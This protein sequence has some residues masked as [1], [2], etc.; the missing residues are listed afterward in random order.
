MHLSPQA[1]RAALYVVSRLLLVFARTN[2]S[3]GR[4][5]CRDSGGVTQWALECLFNCP[6]N[7]STI[8]PPSIVAAP[9]ETIASTTMATNTIDTPLPTP[10]MIAT[11]TTTTTTMVVETA[12]ATTIMI[13]SPVVVQSD[14]A[15]D[16]AATATPDR[17]HF[18]SFEDWRDAVLKHNLQLPLAK[19][20]PLPPKEQKDTTNDRHNRLANEDYDGYGEDSAYLL[21]ADERLDHMAAS[22]RNAGSRQAHP[23]VTSVS[24]QIHNGNNENNEQSTSLNT[25]SID[26]AS[27]TTPLQE[28]DATGELVIATSTN[29]G[30]P[31][32]TPPID[33]KDMRDQS[34]YASFDCGATVLASNSEAKGSTAILFDTKEQYMLNRC[35]ASK[36]VVIELCDEILVD[37][38]MLANHEFFS[39]MFK[40]FRISVTDQYIRSGNTNW[41]TLGHYQARNARDIQAFHIENP[42]IW[43][44]YLRIDFLSHYGNE[45]YCPVSVIKVYGPT[46]MEQYRREEQAAESAIADLIKDSQIINTQQQQNNRLPDGAQ[47]TIDST[48]QVETTVTTQLNESIENNKASTADNVKTNVLTSTEKENNAF[49]TTDPL[50][51]ETPVE[52][53]VRRQQSMKWILIIQITLK[54]NQHWPFY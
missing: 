49:N 39:S 26:D 37:T 6:A 13:A 11:V 20:N 41:R 10:A 25:S 21:D 28:T 5:V 51:Q 50:L 30:V 16:I 34:N 33:M 54:S 3:Y 48:G 9:I 35:S 47:N 1:A 23:T 32:P 2:M 14:A 15:P 43:T 4:Y 19:N 52:L 40:D 12:A 7:T 45:Y 38:V 44:R 42:I 24:D 31:V 46:M 53:I 18:P 8:M 17:A 27:T 22:R 29:V 36:F